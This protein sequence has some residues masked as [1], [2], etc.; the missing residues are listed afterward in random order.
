MIYVVL[1]M[2]KSGTTLT[3]QILHHSGINMDDEIDPSVS[4]DEGNKYERQSILH[5]NLEILGT[6]SYSTIDLKAPEP[7]TAGPDLQRRMQEVIG[8]CERR[9]KDWGFKD[10]RTALTY[11]LWEELLPE[12]RLIVVYRGPAAVWPHYRYHGP[13]HAPGNIGRAWRFLDRWYD[14]NVRILSILES[15]PYEY[16]VL[17]Y[18]ELMTSDA[19]F[20]R[21]EAFMGRH[22][23]D[24]RR[25]DLFRHRNGFSPY[26]AIAERMLRSRYGRIEDV[27]A[28]MAAV[29]QRQIAG[30]PPAV[31]SSTGTGT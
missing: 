25:P 27:M 11:P 1:G 2:H 29:R 6:D 10:P 15:T 8:T 31:P 26:M 17:A 28:R 4:Y 14:Y 20:A 9:Y 21:L 30:N 16:L 12:H 22:L 5:L 13:H 18:D 3:S 23:E 24:C 7:L 19:E